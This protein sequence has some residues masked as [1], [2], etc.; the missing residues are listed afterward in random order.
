MNLQTLQ[1]IEEIIV[2]AMFA[3]GIEEIV[4]TAI[5]ATFKANQ[6]KAIV[7]IPDTNN[8]YGHE[9]ISNY[10]LKISQLAIAKITTTLLNTFPRNLHVIAL[11][12]LL[13]NIPSAT[14][15]NTVSQYGNDNG[16]LQTHFIARIVQNTIRTIKERIL[17]N[18]VNL[19]GQHRV[20]VEEAMAT[21][22]F[23]MEKY[24]IVPTYHN[25]LFG[26]FQE[27][28]VYAHLLLF[29]GGRYT[30][31][32][33]DLI[34]Q[35]VNAFKMKDKVKSNTIDITQLY[36]WT[37]DTDV[38][39][40]LNKKI[41]ALINQTY[42][43]KT[44]EQQTDEQQTYEQKEQK[45]KK[46]TDEQKTE[47]LKQLI[48]EQSPQTKGPATLNMLTQLLFP[49]SFTLQE[50]Q[51]LENLSNQKFQKLS[52][53]QDKMIMHAYDMKKNIIE[54]IETKAAMF[55]SMTSVITYNQDEKNF[56]TLVSKI[57]KRNNGYYKDINDE[58]SLKLLFAQLRL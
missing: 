27:Y 57:L 30:H 11:L 31:N 52:G 54:K 1:T 42:E 48:M 20:I 38:Y 5:K 16:P 18:P 41:A 24:F 26:N 19:N 50:C 7:K 8:R 58:E 40:K 53:Q 29:N 15:Y 6:K 3:A 49:D 44:D 55:K 34:I 4:P 9:L 12:H 14:F 43:Q 47:N 13:V 10:K 22:V 17:A 25:F 21:M 39:S 33:A 46:K 45:D 56:N 36:K 28:Q 35:A 2:K 32:I 23:D 37:S 51:T